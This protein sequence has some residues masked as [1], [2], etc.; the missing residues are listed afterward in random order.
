MLKL[1]PF[2]SKNLFFWNYERTIHILKIFF[3]FYGPLYLHFVFSCIFSNL[4]WRLYVRHKHTYFY[5]SFFMVEMKIVSIRWVSYSPCLSGCMSHTQTHTHQS[6]HPSPHHH[7]FVFLFKVSERKKRF[8]LVFKSKC[9]WALMR[10]GGMQC[11]VGLD[12]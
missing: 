1:S 3:I 7:S 2:K 10:V 12:W 11:T 8:F 5:F 6:I 4:K 9:L